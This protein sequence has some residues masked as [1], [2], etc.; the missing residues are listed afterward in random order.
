MVKGWQV[1]PHHRDPETVGLTRA[2]GRRAAKAGICAAIEN[3]CTSGPVVRHR[4]ADPGACHRPTRAGGLPQPTVV[5]GTPPRY[6]ETIISV[7][8]GSA[9]RRC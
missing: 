8:G 9:P 4:R 6:P 7:R 3:S 1:K 2:V 5:T